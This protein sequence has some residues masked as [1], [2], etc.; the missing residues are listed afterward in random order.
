VTSR[1]D[2]KESEPTL[3]TVMA[4]ASRVQRA[5]RKAVR[6]AALAHKREGA[7][8]VVCEGGKIREIT[9]DEFL[10]PRKNGRKPRPSRR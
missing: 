5:M 10:R 4:H 2:S 8:M 9:A 1:N 3:R 6:E 7:R